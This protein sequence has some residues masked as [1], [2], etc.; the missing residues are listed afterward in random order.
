MV[1]LI[2]VRMLFRGG[3][4]RHSVVSCRAMPCLSIILTQSIIMN[5]TYIMLGQW[6]SGTR[7]CILT[8]HYHEMKEV[9]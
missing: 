8:L 5:V 1:T 2:T 4:T 3:E 6:M 7:V 9:Q